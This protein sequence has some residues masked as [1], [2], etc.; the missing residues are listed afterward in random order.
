VQVPDAEIA[1]VAPE[2]EQVESLDESMVSETVSPE[3]A[4]ASTE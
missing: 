3:V 2:I 1:T 4:V